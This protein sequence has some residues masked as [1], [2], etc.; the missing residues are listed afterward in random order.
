MMADDLLFTMSMAMRELPLSLT[1]VLYRTIGEQAEEVPSS[2]CVGCHQ[3]SD[4][5]CQQVGISVRNC[6]RKLSY[7]QASL[8]A[9]IMLQLQF[10]LGVQQY[11][12]RCR[13]NIKSGSQ[14]D[15][16]GNTLH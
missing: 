15:L 3:P 7:R 12:G 6:V 1:V 2:R 5:A 13:Y 8:G 16:V 9:V 4:N 11:V 10:E 14:T